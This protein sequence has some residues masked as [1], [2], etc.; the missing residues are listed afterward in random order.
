MSKQP[1][2]FLRNVAIEAA[3]A[4]RIRHGPKHALLGGSILSGTT[5]WQIAVQA[6]RIG[7]VRAARWPDRSACVPSRSPG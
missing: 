1:F 4:C 3:T 2:K 5:A 6:G 7:P